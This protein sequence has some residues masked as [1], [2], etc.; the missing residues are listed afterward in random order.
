MFANRGKHVG[1][2]ANSIAS[3]RSGKVDKGSSAA[4]KLQA[5]DVLEGLVLQEGMKPRA[6]ATALEYYNALRDLKPG[7]KVKLKVQRNGNQRVVEL[8][9]GQGVDEQRPLLSLVRLLRL[10]FKPGCA[11]SDPR[12]LV[13]NSKHHGHSPLR[14]AP[15]SP[16][17]R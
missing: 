7:T 9:V 3:M 11:V 13:Q 12:R 10:I 2:V 1:K 8:D 17:C 4:G 6:F 15:A 5:G 14:K 16:D